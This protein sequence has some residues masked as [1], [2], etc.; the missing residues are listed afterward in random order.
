MSRPPMSPN[1]SNTLQQTRNSSRI[2]GRGGGR[3]AAPHPN[4]V[5]EYDGSVDTSVAGETSSVHSEVP[6]VPLS[7]GLVSLSIHEALTFDGVELALHP[8]VFVS[9]PSTTKLDAG[10][11]DDGTKSPGT[12]EQVQTKQ[13]NRI[14]PGDLVEIRVW[15]LRPGAK[16]DSNTK[17]SS[18]NT[19]SALKANS[20]ITGG[21]NYHSRNPSLITLSSILSPGGVQGVHASRG[22]G[23]YL[24]NTPLLNTPLS[25][26]SPGDNVSN[27]TTSIPPPLP[28]IIGGNGPSPTARSGASFQYTEI[29]DRGSS[30]NL[31]DLQGENIIDNF[32]Q[33]EQVLKN[34]PSTSNL[35]SMASTLLT[36][37]TIPD[38]LVPSVPLLSQNNMPSFST[39][40]TDSLQGHSRD[41]S[42]ITNSSAMH[43]SSHVHI[44]SLPITIGCHKISLNISCGVTEQRQLSHVS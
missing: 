2:M 21:S 38:S 44:T 1:P 14:R 36:G 17:T 13:H 5:E 10:I 29:E 41:S 24:G 11:H 26:T 3:P 42:L 12:S 7:T 18:S 16:V 23:M 6:E 27:D 30:N 22:S 20:T 33:N 4:A 32:R 34:T 19:S 37:V 43:V 40:E 25:L 15:T 8:D 28:S 39:V 31:S 35:S 9:V